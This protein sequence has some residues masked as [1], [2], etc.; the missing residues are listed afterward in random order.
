MK[1][2][3]LLFLIVS[4]VIC[5]P[6]MVMAEGPTSCE[7]VSNGS[8]KTVEIKVKQEFNKEK[9]FH[10]PPKEIDMKN[11]KFINTSKNILLKI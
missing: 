5:F 1:K 4:F 8:E 3:G 11:L 2:I 10:G 6:F 7:K 9:F